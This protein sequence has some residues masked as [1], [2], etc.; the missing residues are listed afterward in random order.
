M[1]AFIWQSKN[2][3]HIAKHSVTPAEAEYIVAHARSPYPEYIGDLKYRVGGQT[4]HGR[5]LQVIYVFGVDAEDI[6]WEDV[7]MT[8]VDMDDPD[9]FYV[10]HAMELPKR[11][12]RQYRRRR[13]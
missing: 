7:D 10:V 13:K 1:A 12:R 11:D 3:E 6:D 8:L 5:Y 2:A 9:L 4:E